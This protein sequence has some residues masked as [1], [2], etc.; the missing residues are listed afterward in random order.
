MTMHIPTITQHG[1]TNLSVVSSCTERPVHTKA[2]L[3]LVCYF[4]FLGC[5]L[6][7]DPIEITGA[8]AQKGV[9]MYM[10]GC[11]PAVVRYRDFF[12]TVAHMTGGQ[13]VPLTNAELLAKVGTTL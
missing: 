3:N 4:N 10:V 12:M 13:Y 8:L 1:I 6:K 2:K 5:P 11:E 7:L 9:T